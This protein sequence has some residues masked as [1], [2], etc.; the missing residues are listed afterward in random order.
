LC[1]IASIRSTKSCLLAFSF[2]V[3]FL[4]FRSFRPISEGICAGFDVAFVAAD[5]ALFEVDEEGARV[6]LAILMKRGVIG[7]I[8][9]RARPDSA[10]CS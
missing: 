8:P 9:I 6:I 10:G 4:P 3:G 1:A 7:E 5:F 2:L